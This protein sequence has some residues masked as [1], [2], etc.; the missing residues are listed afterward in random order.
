MLAIYVLVI[1]AVVGGIASKGNW[2]LL[3]LYVPLALVGA[4][5]GAF[6]AFGD[7]LFLARNRI[8]S[9][10]TLAPLGSVAL[11]WGAWLWRRSRTN[12]RSD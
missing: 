5:L 10:F 6:V 4:L 8:F 2:R 12:G 3:L 9:P 1:A 11:V 7:V